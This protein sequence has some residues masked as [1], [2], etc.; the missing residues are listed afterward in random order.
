[1]TNAFEFY[2]ICFCTIIFSIFLLIS[3]PRREPPS[4]RPIIHDTA[5][6]VRGVLDPPTA[7]MDTLLRSRAAPNTRLHR[8][9]HL[10]NT[11]VSPDPM[12]HAAFLRQSRALLQTAKRDWDRFND[13]AL[14]AV[15][16]SLLNYATPFHVFVRA[17]TLRTVIVGLLDPRIDITSLASSDVDV[18]GQLIT[19]LWLLSKNPEYIPEHLL[20]MLNNRLRRLI[21]DDEKY[22]NPLD[23]VIPAFET[24]WRLV[25]VTLAHVHTDAAACGAFR[26]FNE[27]PN[28][29]QFRAS[30]LGGT[31]PS[32][33]D[34]ISE[35]LRLN[36]PVRHITRHTYK[37]SLLTAILPRFLAAWFPPRIEVLVA[38]IESAQRTSFWESDESSADVYDAARFLHEATASHLL[39]FGCGPLKCAAINWAPMAAAVIVGAVLNRVDGVGHY[40]VRGPRIGGR[41][42]W[43]RWEFCLDHFELSLSVLATFYIKL[44]TAVAHRGRIRKYCASKY[45][46]VGRMCRK[47]DAQMGGNNHYPV[48]TLPTEIVLKIFESFLPGYPL[49]PPLVGPAS[50]TVLTQVCREWREIALAAPALWRAMSF[51]KNDSDSVSTLVEK[52]LAVVQNWLL[53]SRPLPISLCCIVAPATAMSIHAAIVPHRNRWEHLRL[54]GTAL[55][56]IP[57]DILDGAMPLLRDLDLYFNGNTHA[58]SGGMALNDTPLLCSAALNYV[59]AKS[60]IL[61]YAQLTTL[62]LTGSF[63]LNE[64]VPL[65]HQASNLV[66]C[67]L[68]VFCYAN[69]HAA[70]DVTLPQLES[71]TLQIH[72]LDGHPMQQSFIVPALR[73][74]HIAESVATPVPRAIPSLKVFLDKAGCPRLEEVRITN[75]KPVR[76]YD[77]S[78]SEYDASLSEDV[79]RTAFPSISTFI[80][81]HYTARQRDQQLAITSFLLDRPYF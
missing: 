63:L 4:R 69:E 12:V 58:T 28:C 23:F 10:S 56:N 21:P 34:Y 26:D 43:D 73:C 38:D 45:S 60:F 31:S 49:H 6:A 39:A 11:F 42:E 68:A 76:G 16:L 33:E 66:H 37:Q 77:T 67:D 53:R 17:A 54:R 22:A 70:P 8:T 19:D 44:P 46:N 57:S 29:E 36:P 24:L 65:L 3:P 72:S 78:L 30:R 41:E 81:V 47:H 80:L 18:V 48:L 74:L 32:V 5:A 25:A 1:M 62:R 15:E 51:G 75:P 71:L 9:F 55:D 35:A 50:P 79:Y 40:I 27:N 7:S 61:P 13:V 20:E 59:A 52:Q 64:C 2:G 14:Q